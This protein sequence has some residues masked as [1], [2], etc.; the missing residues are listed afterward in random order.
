MEEGPN[1]GSEGNIHLFFTRL[2]VERDEKIKG[3]EAALDLANSKII[4]Q[5]QVGND[6]WEERFEKLHAEHQKAK[7]E[8]QVEINGFR[9]QING[10]NTTIDQLRADKPTGAQPAEFA[11]GSSKYDWGIGIFGLLIGVALGAFLGMWAQKRFMTPKNE[12]TRVFE[13]LQSKHQFNF[14]YEIANGRFTAL[15]SILQE[16]ISAPTNQTVKPEL[17]F[18]RQ[19][20]KASRKKMAEHN[21]PMSDAGFAI[22]PNNEI[23]VNEKS[24]QRITITEPTLSVR[25]EASTTAD[26]L[27]TLKKDDVVKVMD[28]GNILDK[29]TTKYEGKKAEIEDIWYKVE[30]PNGM[31]GWIFGYYT[32]AS[33]NAITVFADGSE[34]PAAV[35][36]KSAI[37]DSIKVIAPATPA[38]KK[39]E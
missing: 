23:V 3:L 29:L 35:P 30:M 4:S 33:R 18:I 13:K 17:E 10:L 38:T 39:S 24:R 6:D 16:E 8:A 21:V 15:D 9:S 20:L 19:I 26:K 11:K 7:T 14:E 27:G 37:K 5:P 2:L 25:A 1:T 12:Q 34:T 22:M 32:S 31:E 28:R 36:A